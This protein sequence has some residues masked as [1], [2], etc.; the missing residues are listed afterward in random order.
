MRMGQIHSQCARRSCNCAVVYHR[1]QTQKGGLSDWFP[2]PVFSAYA[3]T[4][5]ARCSLMEKYSKHLLY[6][7]AGCTPVAQQ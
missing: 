3:S 6:Q 4:I 1:K 7:Q 5:A 2:L